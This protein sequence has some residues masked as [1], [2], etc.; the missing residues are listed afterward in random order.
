MDVLFYD[1]VAAQPGEVVPVAHLVVHLRLPG[2]TLPHP[3]AAAV[4]VDAS[5][6][7]VTDHAR[8]QPPDPFPVHALIVL[9]QAHDHV[10]L[11]FLRDLGRLEHLP[12]T[13]RIGGH[14]LFHEHVLSRCNRRR[15]VDRP[16]PGRRR[17]NHHVRQRDHLLVGVYPHEAVLPGNVHLRR[18][19]SIPAGP[20]GARDGLEA[21]VQPVLEGI[22]HGHQLHVG[23]RAQGLHGGAG[24]AS[25]AAHEPHPDR[26]VERAGGV[27]ARLEPHRGDAEGGG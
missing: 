26:V 13:G 11:L 8:V 22:G 7:D 3:D 17:E 19:V 15:Q 9:L 20:L 24:A 21:A 25:T 14:R 2:L 6:N 18:E 27:G 23:P 5:Q 10:E 1:V 4:P 16:E 12:D